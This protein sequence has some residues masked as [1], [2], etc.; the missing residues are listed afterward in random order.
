MDYVYFVKNSDDG[1]IKIGHTCRL[2][3]RMRSL[4]RNDN[5][6]PTLLGVIPGGVRKLRDIQSKFERSQLTRLTV[7]GNV[8]KLGWFSPHPDL[9]EFI[10]KNTMWNDDCDYAKNGINNVGS[11]KRHLSNQQAKDA[12]EAFSNGQSVTEIALYFGVSE[13]VIRGLVTGKTYKSAGGPVV[14]SIADSNR[15]KAKLAKSRKSAKKSL[16]RKK[17]KR[18]SFVYF[19]KR[20]SDGAIKIGFTTSLVNRIYALNRKHGDVKLIGVI[21]GGMAREG[22]LHTLFNELRYEGTEF[23]EPSSKLL[24]FIESETFLPK[25]IRLQNTSNSQGA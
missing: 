1:L 13:T 6:V 25:N 2:R 9:I 17:G 18:Q 24:K 21:E 20:N 15:N 5:F 23:F 14:S 7:Y 10:E 19:V 3:S 16:S 12:R 4:M 22:I 11:V 8:V